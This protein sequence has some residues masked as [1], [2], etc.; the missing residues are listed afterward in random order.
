MTFSSA[1]VL[2][3]TPSTAGNYTFQVIL[4]DSSASNTYTISIH[5]SAFAITTP[6]NLP[7]A[8]TNVTYT[9]ANPLVTMT[10]SGGSNLTWSA[11][12]LPPGLSMSSS[13]A[14]TGSTT[15]FATRY[16]PTISVTDG[17]TQTS[18]LFTM[19]TETPNPTEL[20]FAMSSTTLADATIGHNYGAGLVP[21]GGVPPYTVS[22][23]AGSTLPP[24]LSLLTAASLAGSPAPG[25]TQLAG[26]PTMAGQY[27]FNLVFS[28]S[29]GSHVTRAMTLNVTPVAIFTT[30]PNAAT[31]GSAYSQQLIAF[32]GT[33]PYTFTLSPNSLVQ[34]MLPPGLSVS[35]SGLLSG[36]PTGTGSFT[37]ILKIQ[38]S[39]GNTL[40]TTLTVTANN[41]NG[42]RINTTNSSSV[43]GISYAGFTLSTSGQSTYTWSVQ[44][45]ALPTGVT[46]NSAGSLSG[47]TTTPGVFQFTLR[48]TDNNNSSNFADR[49]LTFTVTPLELVQPAQSGFTAQVL[50]PGTVGSAYS[51]AFKMAGGTPPYSFSQSQFI[52]LPPGM[53]LTSG[54]VLSGTPTQSGNFTIR[55]VV[56]DANGLRYINS[57]L[58]LAITPAGGKPPLIPRGNEGGNEPSVGAPFN[59]LLDWWVTGGTPPYTWSVT[60]GSA[61][62]GITIING[63]NGLP[64]YLTGTFQGTGPYNAFTLTA[65]D[66]GGQS[67]SFPINNVSASPLTLTPGKLPTGTTGSAYSVTFTAG[68]GTAPYT[69]ALDPASNLPPG[70]SL[71]N[72]VLSGTPLYPGV[73][74]LQL[75]VTDNA[76]GAL[77]RQY[78]LALDDPL[79]EAPMISATPSPI[80]VTY[81]QG[82]AAQSIPIQVNSTSGNLA[83]Q[84]GIEGVSGLSLTATSGNTNGSITLNIPANLPLGS[85][86]G[87]I[88]FQSAGADNIG[89]TI[90]LNVNVTLPPQTITFNPLSNVF[91]GVAAFQITATASS[92]LQVSFI[93]NSTSVCTVSGS[94]VTILALGTCSITANQGGNSMYAPA[95]S[96]TRTFMVVL[97]SPPSIVSLTPS[98]G[99]GGAQV[100]TAV[101]SDPDGATDITF[102]QMVIGVA[103]NGGGQAYCLVHY[104]RAGN[105]LYLYGDGGSFLGPATPG[106]ASNLLKT[107]SCAVSALNSSAAAAGNTL[108][109]SISVAFEPSFAGSKNVYLRA[110]DSINNDTTAMQKGTWT[111]LATH[112]PSGFTVAP[113]SGTGGGGV[114]TATFPDAA[115]FAGANPA[116]AQILFASNPAPTSNFCLVHYDAGGNALWILGDQGFF[117]GPVTP[118]TDS[119]NL[120]NSSCVINPAATTVTHANGQLKVNLVVGFK[121]GLAGPQNVYLH[122]LDAIGYDSGFQQAGTWTATNT[123][124]VISL[125][126]ATS[127]GASERFSAVFF[128][129]SGVQDL[130]WTQMLVAVA[131][132]GGGQE[133][134]YVHYDIPGNGMWLFNDQG[135]FVGPVTPGTSSATLQNSGC[136]IDTSNSSESVTLSNYF[137][138]WNVQFNAKSGFSGTR[139]V[140]LRTQDSF[141]QDTQFVLEGTTTTP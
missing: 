108:T 3:G 1:G 64:G 87:V 15:A 139:N 106:V 65:T 51:Y 138:N 63:T 52:P 115:G 121:P 55:P 75:D 54:G 24:G 59:L 10:A 82:Y 136:S 77:F 79:A 98:S 133:F 114:F 40:S 39:A 17:V 83:F 29:V 86:G 73:F 25:V 99:S 49:L 48:A 58:S 42:L 20:D 23:A 135:N 109:L 22:V 12:S 71:T 43:A 110:V 4:A 5:I 37:S 119:G 91:L 124:G 118:G 93:S 128:H 102:A 32:G 104:D 14:I 105:A 92:G 44:T 89:E 101:F 140:Y 130:K 36:T 11:A 120:Q 90:P 13:G 74:S 95:P 34:D 35:S 56:T 53:S 134:C 116:W 28:D 78:D 2:S 113:S 7:T 68:G 122:S 103:A 125:T 27:S 72:G 47:W 84:A 31:V 69:I 60:G 6:R 111:I 45:G 117:V 19:F 132:N 129:P 26:A 41:A 88:A 100:F 30:S 81:V 141:G 18:L 94:M 76:G 66:A 97:N 70:L 8:I 46:L 126:P 127:S 85:Y 131:T 123:P 21:N 96:V 137:L 38:D 62:P 112:A 9:N 67:L 50:P 57:V 107:S 33:A 61:P 16:V 80:N